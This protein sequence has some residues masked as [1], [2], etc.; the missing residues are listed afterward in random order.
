MDIKI[1]DEQLLVRIFSD[2]LCKNTGEVEPDISDINIKCLEPYFDNVKKKVC[3]RF[4][5]LCCN[6]PKKTVPILTE[7]CHDIFEVLEQ[8]IE[9]SSS[10]I[11][12]SSESSPRGLLNFIITINFIITTTINISEFVS[13]LKDALLDEDTPIMTRNLRLSVLRDSFKIKA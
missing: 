6:G 1:A 9:Q 12:K 7:C 10:L 8:C 4:A 5:Y 2:V 3:E 13:K 11:Q